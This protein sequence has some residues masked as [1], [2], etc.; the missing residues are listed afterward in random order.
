MAN[1]ILKIDLLRYLWNCE[2]NYQNILISVQ[3]DFYKRKY[4]DITDFNRLYCAEQNFKIAKKITSDVE[5][6]LSMY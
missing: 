1:D 3:N 5:R 6:I 2:V 4:H